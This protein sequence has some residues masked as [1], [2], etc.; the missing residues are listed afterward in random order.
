MSHWTW[1]WWNGVWC[2]IWTWILLQIPNVCCLDLA[3]WDATYLEAWLYE[4]KPLP[5]I[6]LVVNSH[7]LNRLQAWGVKNI[8]LADSGHVS[9]SN[10]VRQSLFVHDDAV[11]GKL[12]SK[13]AAERLRD[14]YPGLVCIFFYSAQKFQFLMRHHSLSTECI[15]SFYS[16]TDAWP[17]G[18]W[19]DAH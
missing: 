16:Y 13:T 3:R 19:I 6:V 11:Q 1:S 17:S 9:H 7:I 12:K 4:H 18:R 14:I 5:L 10:P 2:R 15:W 8:T